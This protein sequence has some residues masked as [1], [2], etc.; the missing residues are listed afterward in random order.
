MAD[1][2]KEINIPVDG[3]HCSSCSLLVE[4]SF[5]KLDA[6]DS[7]NVDL[8]KN[9]ARIILNSDLTQEEIDKTVESVGFTVPKE[10]V[11]IQIAGM[12]C[13]SCVN[14]V[15]KFLPRID[16]I[17]EANANLSNQKVTIKY[18]RDMLDL[19]EVKKTIEMLGFEY[20]GLDKDVDILDEE[21]RYEK[22]LR[23]KLYRIIVG[24]IFSAILMIMMLYEIAIPPLDVCQSS[25]LV[26]ILPF[27]YV[28]YPILKAGFNSF[29][30]GNLDM[31]VMYSMGIL[32][33]FISSLFGTFDI[34]LNSSFM[35]Y[36]SA[37]MLPSFLTIG[38]YL[39]ARAKRQTSSSIRELIGLQPKTATLISVDEDG[40][41]VETQID[42]EDIEIGNNLLVKPGEKIPADALVIGGE[43]YVDESMITGEPVPKLKKEGADV[44]AGT[45]NQDSVLKVEAQKIGSE[46][47]LSQ[48]IELV[49]KAQ[50]SKPPVQR[51]ANKAVTW[52][53]PTILA[54]AI[55][56][57]LLWYFVFR[58]GDLLFALTCLISILVVACPCALGLAT[59][60]AVTV[61]VGR[62]AEYGILIKN[63][64]TLES[65][66]DVDTVVFDKTG[67]ITEGKP[68]VEDILT[69]DYDEDKFLQVLSTVENNS[70]H[71]IAK[72]ILNR[73]KDNNINLLE[74]G[75]DDLS[76]L[77][78]EEFENI[79]GKGLKATV[80]IDGE[81]QNVLAGNL[82]LLESEEISVSD[83]V[84]VKFDEFVLKSKTTICMSIGDKV[85]GILT[86]MDKLKPSSKKAINALH[87]MEIDTYMLTGDNEKTAESVAGLVGIDNVMANVLPNDK[88]DKVKE[89]QN[90]GKRVLFVG[91]GIN[92]APALSQADI[93]VAMGNGTDI[94]MESGD[95]VIMEGDLEN[96]VASIQISNKVMTR[97]KE[98][99]FW[100]FAYNMLLVPAAAGILTPLFG[101]YFQPEWGG[102]AMALSS[103]TVVSLSL[104]LKRYVPPIKKET[105]T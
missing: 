16:G 25:L 50:G 18:Y 59:P 3:M 86:L 54:I 5:N 11:V 75:K 15:E 23:S 39:E 88:L 46:T 82:K 4:K 72:A 66:K 96:V 24:M 19:K 52:F 74:D 32:V 8:N 63:G 38:R 7:T 98:N 69:F 2:V 22:D 83:E 51:L 9:Q 28:S 100:A 92:D 87:D 102:L 14:N 68:E 95:T 99:L 70:H 93:G 61:G 44:F 35:F 20:I 40:N 79:T 1:K 17:L 56:A 30:H 29:R 58:P 37:V 77:E 65:S 42:I 90:A 43:S 27:I 103:V 57:S 13:A 67:T 73:F 21:A 81:A 101:I 45:I 78:C 97:I 6:V 62:A 53:I 80:V 94:A 49:E 31:D 41:T 60:T 76:L 89:L 64:E 12:H 55:V 26:A 47:V 85:V 10:E 33:A 104:L 34:I 71:P 48:I 36:D 105:K 91:D 84:L